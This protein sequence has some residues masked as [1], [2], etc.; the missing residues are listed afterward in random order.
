MS[1]PTNT[2]ALHPSQPSTRSD[3]PQINDS[4]PQSR[5]E[6]VFNTTKSYPP[7]TWLILLHRNRPEE[8]FVVTEVSHYQQ[9]LSWPAFQPEYL[10]LLVQPHP[11][12]PQP[13]IA[14]ILIKV[15]RSAGGHGFP[16]RL[17]LWGVMGDKVTILGPASDVQIEDKRLHHLTWDPDRAPNLEVISCFIACVHY[18]ISMNCPLSSSCLA[19]IHATL[20]VIHIVFDG[21]SGDERPKFLIP[22]SHM[23][24]FIR[25][26]TS[27]A[28]MVVMM[29]V[30]HDMIFDKEERGIEVM[31]QLPLIFGGSCLPFVFPVNVRS[32]RWVANSVAETYWVDREG[33][34]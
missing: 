30:I 28:Q 29:P 32:V 9:H 16:A 33:G 1:E 11:R 20:E 22:N 4:V 34:F 24:R 15:S 8:H 12:H 10:T 19:F 27:L 3:R 26:G 13:A 7:L 14:P 25:P 23:V 6:R 17:G 31:L 21:V 2:T 18:D 5:M